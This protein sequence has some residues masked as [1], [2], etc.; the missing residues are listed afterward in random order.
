MHE[1]SD[2]TTVLPSQPPA[3]SEQT[4]QL[5][6]APAGAGRK[7]SPVL[8][9]AGIVVILVIAAAIIFVVLPQ[10]G[11]SHGA[12]GSSSA[13]P[14][15]SLIT[16]GPIMVTPA[17][18]VTT[19]AP[20]TPANLYP[21][22]LKLKQPFTFGSG[23]V[24]SECTVYR[25]WINDTYQWH[26]NFDNHY[27]TQKARDGYKFLFIFIDMVNNGKT[28]VWPPTT[29]KIHLLYGGTE[30]PIYA[31]HSLPAKSI[32]NEVTITQITEMQYQSTLT[33][34]E[35]VEDFGYSHGTKYAFLY[36]GQ[37]NAIDGYLIYEVPDSL[38]ADNT[39]VRIEFNGSDVGVWKLA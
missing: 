6:P 22:A 15:T 24:I 3:G 17:L 20:T 19:P 38:T 5:F 34:S 9:L 12:A 31:G 10:F 39:V 33:G 28:R 36:P 4:P 1:V 30:Y 11:G 2:T 7:K 29:D 25:Y 21:D 18:P 26:N 32:K 37:S 8:F 23:D 35:Y 27:Y 16:T 13:V 14:V